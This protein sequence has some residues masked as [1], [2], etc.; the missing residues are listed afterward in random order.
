[1]GYRLGVDLGAGALEDRGG[2]G[3]AA[4]GPEEQPELAALT[5]AAA[6]QQEAQLEGPAERL[7][8]TRAPVGRRQVAEGAREAGLTL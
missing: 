8:V 2:L 1:M 6:R 4:G 3:V 5:V 7:A